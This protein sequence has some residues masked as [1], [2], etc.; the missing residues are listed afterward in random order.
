VSIT[1]HYYRANGTEISGINDY[2]SI[3][4]EDGKNYVFDWW[5]ETFTAVPSGGGD[6]GEVSSSSLNTMVIAG[7]GILGLLALIFTGRRRK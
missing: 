4:F 1:F 3:T 6:E 5:N 2:N 7:M